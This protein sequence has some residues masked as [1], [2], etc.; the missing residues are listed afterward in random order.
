MHMQALLCNAVRKCN[1]TSLHDASVM[2]TQDDLSPELQAVTRI[3]GALQAMQQM[4]VPAALGGSGGEEE[5]SKA[6][7]DEKNKDCRKEEGKA[8]NERGEPTQAGK[9]AAENRSGDEGE[10][11]DGAEEEKGGGDAGKDETSPESYEPCVPGRVIF[12]ERCGLVAFSGS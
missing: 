8:S 9:D 4:R 5:D 10:A 7:K 2:V 6:G 12:I 3:V 1:V 11:R